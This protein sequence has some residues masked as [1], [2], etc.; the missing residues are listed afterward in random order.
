MEQIEARLDAIQFAVDVLYEE[1][2]ALI[3]ERDRLRRQ[4]EK[5]RARDL[6]K[7]REYLGDAVEVN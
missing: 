3:A 2:R 5:Q 1:S 6:R 4:E 7:A